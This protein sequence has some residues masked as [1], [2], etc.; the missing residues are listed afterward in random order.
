MFQVPG[1]PLNRR[2]GDTMTHRSDPYE[3]GRPV[4]QGGLVDRASTSSHYFNGRSDTY[5]FRESTPADDDRGEAAAYATRVHEHGERPETSFRPIERVPSPPP[6]TH[7]SRQ[8]DKGD[9]DGDDDDIDEDDLSGR[10][11]RTRYR[12][13]PLPHETAAA[14][15]ELTAD[16][17]SCHVA[18][19]PSCHVAFEHVGCRDDDEEV[20]CGE[21]A[22]G[23]IASILT[24]AGDELSRYRNSARREYKRRRSLSRMSTTRENERRHDR[25]SSSSRTRRRVVRSG[26]DRCSTTRRSDERSVTVQERGRARRVAKVGHGADA[27]P[28]ALSTV[29]K[30][31][32]YPVLVST[33]VLSVYLAMAYV[34]VDVTPYVDLTTRVTSSLMSRVGAALVST[35]LWRRLAPLVPYAERIATPLS[36]AALGRT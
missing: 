33:N 20:C 18:T 17:P 26:V 10:D 12:P 3:G 30:Y 36:A 29:M 27:K 23:E 6:Y 21:A 9:D 34:G 24:A 11:D 32:K 1:L 35:D 22:D 2:R 8:A 31:V 14:V 15:A 5:G 4:Y 16:D 13:T 28:S 19:D 7:Q 25:R